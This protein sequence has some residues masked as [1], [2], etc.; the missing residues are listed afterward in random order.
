M[1]VLKRSV[2]NC[3]YCYE[4]RR[5]SLEDEVRFL[6][7]RLGPSRTLTQMVALRSDYRRSFP[8]V[9]ACL[10]AIARLHWLTFREFR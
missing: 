10:P 9:L 4:R 6:N 2:H 7:E 5:S 3:F 8:F 1:G